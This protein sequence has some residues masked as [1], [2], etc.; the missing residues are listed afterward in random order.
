MM[1]NV[2]K[3]IAKVLIFV[4]F[5]LLILSFAVWGIGDI[6]RG[7]GQSTSVAE[8]GTITIEQHEFSCARS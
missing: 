5:G 8:V 2:R 1:T 6:F 4:L 7:P 3:S